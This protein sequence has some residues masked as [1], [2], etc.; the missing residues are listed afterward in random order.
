M[1]LAH[2]IEIYF[3]TWVLIGLFHKNI[4][5]IGAYVF[6]ADNIIIML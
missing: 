5:G 6:F 3:K 1:Q 4:L 2:E